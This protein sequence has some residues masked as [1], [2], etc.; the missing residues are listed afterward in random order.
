MTEAETAG[1]LRLRGNKTH[2]VSEECKMSD[3][4]YIVKWMHC[5]Q[6]L[7]LDFQL[8]ESMMLNSIYDGHTDMLASH[9]SQ[10]D[11]PDPTKRLATSVR[12]WSRLSD[13][14]TILPH[15]ILYSSFD[16]L[17]VRLNRTTL[18]ELRH[19]SRLM[20]QHNARM[21]EQLHDEW[22]DILMKVASY[23]PNHPH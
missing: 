11:V 23:S 22:K 19:V 12:Y 3:D 6:E 7:L 5:L 20:A 17:V 13:W 1:R 10:S 2:V 4:N 15:V 8:G 18:D 21:T 14:Y 9:P 16:D